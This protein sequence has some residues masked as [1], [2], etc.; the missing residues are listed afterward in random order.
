[1]TYFDHQEL[2]ALAASKRPTDPIPTV[3][4]FSGWVFNLYMQSDARA[5]LRGK[6]HEFEI[7]RE[8]RNKQPSPVSSEYELLDADPLDGSSPALRMSSLTLNGKPL[9]GIPDIVFRRKSTGEIVIVE[10]KVTSAHPREWPNLKVQLWCYSRIDKWK[11]T[12]I[13]RMIGSI[14]HPRYE[15]KHSTPVGPWLRGE[16]PFEDECRQLFEIFGG[17]VLGD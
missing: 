3:S 8:G 16:Q 2:L 9:F 7:E 12:P 14:H 1:M 15:L 17:E 4:S 10:R 11:N 13:I 5:M 6:Q